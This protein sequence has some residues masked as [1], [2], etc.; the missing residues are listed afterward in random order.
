MLY[1]REDIPSKS[2]AQIKSES[3]TENISTEINL[4]S[5]K[6]LISGSYK[7]KLSHIKN[8]L[9]EPGEGTEDYSSKYKHFIVLGH[10]NA[11]MSNTYVSDF[12]ALYNL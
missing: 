1:I 2:L 11:E 7:P 6:W 5:K 3:H 8:H 10:F 12:C 9:Q 4:R